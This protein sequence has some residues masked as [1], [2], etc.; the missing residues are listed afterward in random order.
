V[1]SVSERP[2]DRRCP[3]CH[4]ALASAR[5][6]ECDGCRV[7]VHAECRDLL[8]G[9]P[10]LGCAHVTRRAGKDWAAILRALR[11]AQGQAPETRRERPRID[12]GERMRRA[13]LA[14][15]GVLVL[16]VALAVVA[17]AAGG[18]G[19]GVVPMI[20]ALMGCVG[21]L[22]TFFVVRREA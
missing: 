16:A 4:D 5:S 22:V 11:V 20:F 21:A 17:A 12:H 15:C 8:G 3:F 14:G 1:L 13:Y 9:C 18:D 10:T 19:G 7:A 2:A 6:V